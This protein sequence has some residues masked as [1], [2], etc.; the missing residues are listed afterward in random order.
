MNAILGYSEILIEDGDEIAIENFVSS[1]TKIHD[2]AS[3]LL[4]RIDKH[5]NQTPITSKQNSDIIAENRN[6][7]NQL[8]ELH[9]KIFS[10]AQPNNQEVKQEISGKLLIVDDN[11]MNCE[12]LLRHVE[13]Q[14]HT[15]VTVSN[16]YE[17]LKR[18]G[19]QDFDTVLLDL[20]MPIMDGYEV[21][22]KMRD[23]PKLCHIPV[24]MISA[25]DEFDNVV[26]CIELGAQDYLTK[27]F[28]QVLL[29]A[30]IKAS[31]QRKRLHDLEIHYLKQIDAERSVVDNLLQAI[32]PKVIA[33]ELKTTKQVKP[34]RHE[35]VAVMFLDL[36]GFTK[37]CNHRS[38]EEVVTELQQIFNAF[39]DIALKHKVDKTKTIGDAFMATAGLL[40]SESNPVLNCV[41]CGLEMIEATQAMGKS[42]NARVGIHIGPVV[43][44]VVGKR[45]YL[46]D[47]WGDTV[48]TASRV[49]SNGKPGCVYLSSA[50][51]QEVKQQCN[52]KSVG[53]VAVKG[54]GH[55]E[56]FC[57]QK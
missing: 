54:K 32:F 51:W 38:P 28:N 14:G 17:A 18:L 53:K 30:R 20:L 48:N 26:K 10:Q 25:M 21:L 35:N 27:P 57:I 37:Y 49:E 42:W 43:A 33:E 45:Q 4:S 55:L 47:V 50:A 22:Q 23:D 3:Q 11:A 34:R 44:G 39:E 19:E 2:M 16:G 1:I 15:A 52:G 41:L 13:R 24:I 9:S 5:S 36:V 6:I 31:L 29:N 46:F 56:L 12:V 7:E 40:A 8:S